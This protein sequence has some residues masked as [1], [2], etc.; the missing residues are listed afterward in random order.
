MSKNKSTLMHIHK[1][2]LSLE[3]QQDIEKYGF[4]IYKNAMVVWSGNSDKRVLRLIDK[5]SLDYSDRL[6]IA[7]LDGDVLELVWKQDVPSGFDS[8][9]LDV[10]NGPLEIKSDVWMVPVMYK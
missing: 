5:L 6:L 1:D 2:E 3:I 9:V 10:A 8:N 4:S 7:H